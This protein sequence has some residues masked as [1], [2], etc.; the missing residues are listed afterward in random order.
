MQIIEQ[1]ENLLK[2]KN[3]ERLHMKLEQKYQEDFTAQT[4]AEKKALL[5]R[6][7]ALAEISPEPGNLKQNFCEYK[8]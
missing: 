6:K 8:E 7:R 4:L 2:A 1:N 5:E 3:A